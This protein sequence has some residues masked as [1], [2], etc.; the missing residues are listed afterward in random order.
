MMKVQKRKY[1]AIAAL[2]ALM[3][4]GSWAV[5]SCRYPLFDDINLIS[6]FEQWHYDK[7]FDWNKVLC[8]N[9]AYDKTMVPVVDDFGDTI[10]ST[11]ITDRASLLKLLRIIEDAN[12]KEV[13]IDVRFPKFL[14]TD[15]AS[16]Y[17]LNAYSATSVALFSQIKKMRNTLVANHGG[18]VMEDSSLLAKSAI[19]DYGATIFT[20]IARYEYR[21]DAG[22]SVALRMYQD[23]DKGNLHRLGFL[24]FDGWRLCRNAQFVHIP[25][26]VTCAFHI[27][28]G[29]EIQNYPLLSSQLLRYN[30][31]EDIR[32]NASGKVVLI[33]DFDNDMHT[34][35]AGDVPGPILNYLA[36][37]ELH[38][39]HHLMGWFEVVRLIFFACLLYIIIVPGNPIKDMFCRI[40]FMKNFLAKRPLLRFAFSFFGMSF[41]VACFQIFVAWWCFGISMSVF[42]TSITLTIINEIHR[43]KSEYSPKQ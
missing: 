16:P 42:A 15:G 29:M 43:Y 9:V 34:T 30:N 24:A 1:L 40:S 39:G 37:N 19:A 4:V 20:G 5:E 33:G 14:D 35:Y 3:L 31:A 8:V 6:F 36:Y 25:K 10:G 23:M 11:A 27:D 18:M 32:K 17:T 12:Y 22:T 41:V 38:E 2:S 7:G 13:F 21:Q 28:D 26:D